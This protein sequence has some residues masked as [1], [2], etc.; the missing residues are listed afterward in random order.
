MA[1][2][3]NRSVRPSLLESGRRRVRMGMGLE[4]RP[5]RVRVLHGDAPSLRRI[6]DVSLGI[7]ASAPVA[8]NV[9]DDLKNSMATLVGD[10]TVAGFLLGIILLVCLMFIGVLLIAAMNRNGGS[11]GGMGGYMFFG[12]LLFSL[13]LNSG[14]GWWPWWSAI[15]VLVVFLFLITV[16]RATGEGGGV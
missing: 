5:P 11:D 1:R 4:G 6:R 13:I 10:A 14:V 3:G 16:N 9:F 15:P 7:A 8:A 12:F 2:P